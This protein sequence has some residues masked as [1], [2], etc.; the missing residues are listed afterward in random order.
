LVPRRTLSVD[1][2]T[3]PKTANDL[4]VLPDPEHAGSEAK[5]VSYLRTEFQEGGG[6]FSPD[7]RWIAYL[8]TESGSPQIYVRPFFPDKI[9][10]SAAGGRWLVSTVSSNMPPH[11]RGDSKEIYYVS[12]TGQLMGV[13]IDTQKSFQYEAPKPIFNLPLFAP[14]DMTPEGKRVLI[15]LPEGSNAPSPFSIVTNWHAVLQR[16]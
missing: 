8:S 11:W 9:A 15:P 10:E 14:F 16:R 4:W 1:Q 6:A 7:G 13:S 12:A 2:T 3:D 5:P